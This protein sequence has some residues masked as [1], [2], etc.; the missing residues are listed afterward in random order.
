MIASERTGLADELER[1]TPEQW[2]TP[3]L[4]TGWTVRDVA[5]HL[6]L[7]Q[8]GLRDVLGMLAHTPPS[9]M[10]RMIREAARRKADVPT[11]QLGDRD[12]RR[13]ARSVPS[14]WCSPAA[15]RRRC[16][17]SPARAG[18]CC[19]ADPDRGSSRAWAIMWHTVRIMTAFSLII[20][21]RVGTA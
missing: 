11:E 15:P 19:S 1:L 20:G 17:R 4:C 12:R 6:T 10:N 3:S 16:P 8:Q 2:A 21:R 9:G 14:C 13:E 5:A 18:P 7:Q